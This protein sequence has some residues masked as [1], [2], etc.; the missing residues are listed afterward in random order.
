[1]KKVR[2]NSPVPDLYHVA[3]LLAH[4]AKYVERVRRM[5]GGAADAA[6]GPLEHVAERAPLL[7]LLASLISLSCC[8]CRAD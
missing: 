7:D 3:I 4:D 6:L 2:S 8:G 5:S 1:M